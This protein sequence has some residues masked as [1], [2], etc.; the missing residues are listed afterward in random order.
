MKRKRI[1]LPWKNLQQKKKVE[2]QHQKDM[3]AQL[4]IT[5]DLH[6]KLNDVSEG[7]QERMEK[8][9]ALEVEKLACEAK[10][11]DQESKMKRMQDTV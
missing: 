5:S 9:A 8:V 1:S 10:L 7:L 4:K 6:S 11:L 3:A 2:D